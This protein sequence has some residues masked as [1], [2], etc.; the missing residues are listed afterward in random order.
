MPGKHRRRYSRPVMSS[1]W[2]MGLGFLEDTKAG[3][4]VPAAPRMTVAFTHVD[5]G[6]FAH[7][8]CRQDSHRRM[9][10]ISFLKETSARSSTKFRLQQ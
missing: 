9:S 2:S 1:I 3:F 4:S 10:F 8:P 5:S 7:A 6:T